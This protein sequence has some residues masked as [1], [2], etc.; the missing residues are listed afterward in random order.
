MRTLAR[1]ALCLM[2]IFL[3]SIAIAQG[4]KPAGLLRIGVLL[5]GSPATSTRYVDVLREALRGYGL[6][7]GKNIS[8]EP[9]FASGDYERLPALANE[10]VDVNVSL[11]VAGNEQA[12]LAAKKAKRPIPIVVVACNPLERLVGNLSRPG[13]N[14]TGVTCISSDLVGKRLG[15]LKAIVPNVKRVAVFYH[16]DDEA[17]AELAGAQ[18]AGRTLGIDVGRFPVHSPSDFAPVFEK[19]ARQKF[20]AVYVSASGFTN[21]HRQ[22]LADLAL[23]HRIPGVYGF[24]EFVEAGGLVSY[25]ATLSDGFKRAAYFVDKIVKGASPKDLPVEEP[26]NFYLVLNVKT[27]AALGVKI[28]E[29]VLLQ[30]HTI[31]K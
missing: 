31:I 11:I 15:Y 30:A 12:L 4:P 10:L 8:L 13:G 16:G 19:I 18:S 25:G 27:A 21:F 5:A 6:T 23:A 3:S 28:P 22:R 1:S 20:D 9:R 7:D 24:P 17:N 14:A 2:L 29:D 26:T